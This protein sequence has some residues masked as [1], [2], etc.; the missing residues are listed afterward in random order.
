MVSRLTKELYKWY[1][2]IASLVVTLVGFVVA[3][4]AALGTTYQDYG[5]GFTGLGIVMF[6]IYAYLSFPG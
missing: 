1:L 6:L 4:D 5:W 3:A 2:L